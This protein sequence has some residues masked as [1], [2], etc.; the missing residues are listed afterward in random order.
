MAV[1][2]LLIIYISGY[3]YHIFFA[4]IKLAMIQWLD[5]LSSKLLIIVMRVL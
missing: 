1:D 2:R 5:F 4:F 3:S